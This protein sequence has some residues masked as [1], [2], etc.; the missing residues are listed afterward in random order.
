MLIMKWL[1]KMKL[2]CKE[3]DDDVESDADDAIGSG[4][5]EKV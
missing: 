2:N 1:E 5:Y 4:S 3:V